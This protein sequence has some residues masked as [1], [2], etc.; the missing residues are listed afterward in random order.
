MKFN[1]TRGEYSGSRPMSL[2]LPPCLGIKRIEEAISQRPQDIPGFHSNKLTL[3][4]EDDNQS[5]FR[6]EPSVEFLAC[7]LEY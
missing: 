5:V 7:N 2:H 6:M 3:M 1:L 4:R